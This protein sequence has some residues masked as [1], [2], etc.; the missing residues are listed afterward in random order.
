M[1]SWFSAFL[2]ELKSGFVFVVSSGAVALM[3]NQQTSG[4]VY[5]ELKAQEEKIV[6]NEAPESFAIGRLWAGSGRFM[7]NYQI[8]A[9]GQFIESGLLG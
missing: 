7:R 6:M 4:D 3:E 1:N 2:S 5:A 9:L 8:Y